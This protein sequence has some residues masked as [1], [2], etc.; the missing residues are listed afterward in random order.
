MD[1]EDGLVLTGKA[2]EKEQEAKAWSLYLAIRPNMT[3]ETFMPFSEFYRVERTPV[4]PPKTKDEILA[5]VED[6]KRLYARK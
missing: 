2:A 3:E 5:D 4:V 6:I 1:F